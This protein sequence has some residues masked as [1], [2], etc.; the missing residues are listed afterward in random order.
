MTVY[1]VG[2]C[3]QSPPLDSV[4]PSGMQF[5]SLLSGIV[6]YPL[7]LPMA[8]GKDSHIRCASLRVMHAISDNEV[9]RVNTTKVYYST[10]LVWEFFTSN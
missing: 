10:N 2:M 3:L 9:Q 5:G 7:P 1:W 4:A 8:S 6:C